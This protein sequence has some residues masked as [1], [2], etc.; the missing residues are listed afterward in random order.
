MIDYL[1]IAQDLAAAQPL[2]RTIHGQADGEDFWVKQS[3]PSKSRIWH[4]IQ[5][6][7]AAILPYPILRATVSQGGGKGLQIE[8]D[9]LTEFAQKGVHVP[10]V[11]AINNNLFVLNH[12][13][14][15]LSHH[16]DNADTETRDA[17]LIEATNAL[18]RLHNG[19]LVHGRPYLRDMTW[20]GTQIGF[21]DLEENPLSVMPLAA[22]QA[23]DIWIFLSA[24]SKYARRNGDKYTY[25]YPI[26]DVVWNA[27]LPQANPDAINE[28]RRFIRLIAPL[29]KPVKKYCWLK[30]GND[31]RR[32]TFVTGYLHDRLNK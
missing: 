7:L 10:R 25:D 22:G 9:R 21:L 4:S 19:G 29:V 31:V 1:S 11:L 27:Y 26:M 28:L 13:G 15:C 23:R 18:A 2:E 14:P 24:V 8:A 17:L 32:A 6:W 30:C 5:R 20:D 16:L 3:V 12:L